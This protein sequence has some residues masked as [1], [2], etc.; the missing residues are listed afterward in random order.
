MADPNNV[1]QEAEQ[2]SEELGSKDKETQE[3]A[4]ADVANT[5]FDKEYE[6]AQQNETGSGTQSSDPNPVGRKSAESGTGDQSSSKTKSG[7][8]SPGDSDPDDYRDMAKDIAKDA[9]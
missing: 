3:K 7:T 9:K 4:Q 2:L 1:P 6:I 5:Q 8:K